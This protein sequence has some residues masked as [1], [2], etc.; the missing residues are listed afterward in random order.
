MAPPPLDPGDKDMLRLITCGSVDNGKSTL[1]GRLLFDAR[2]VPGDHLEALARD[3]K[4]YGT[5]G[6]SPDLALLVDGLQAE[7]EQ[8][9]TIDVAYRFFSTARRRF[10]VADTPGHAQYTRNMV[11]GASTADLAIVI[12]DARKGLLAQTFR[13]STI[14]ALMGVR[15]V[16]LAVNKMDLVDYSEQRFAEIVAT[17]SLL[18]R[19]LEL[20]AV[21]AIPT[22]ALRGDNVIEPGAAMPWYRGPTLL[23]HLETVDV[24]RG[25]TRPFRLAVQWINRNGADFRGYAGSVLG[26]SIRTGEEIVVQPSGASNRIARIVT[27]DGDLAEAGA[28]QAVTLTLTDAFDVARGDVLAA[29]DR[30][31]HVAD[32][33]ACHLVW[34]H[35]APMLPGRPYLLQLGTATLTA[36]VTE[37]KH[38]IDVEIGVHE[39]TKQ[40]ALNEIG[41]ANVALDRPAPFDVYNENRD[42]GSFIMIDRTSNATVGA[43][44]IRFPLRRASNLPWQA[45]A[46]DKASRAR[47]KH[48]RPCVLWF[49]GLSGSGK[50]TIADGVEKRLL[51][52]GRHTYSLDGDNVRHG[53][54]RDLGFTDADRVENV[55]RVIEVARLFCEAGLIVLVSVISPFRS[56]RQLARERMADDEFVEIFVDTPFAECERRDPKGLYR[57]AREGKITNFTG[58]DSP[59][60]APE[61][62]DIHI[63]TTEMSL[64]GEIES[65]MKVLRDRGVIG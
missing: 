17:Y 64:E 11:T 21:T 40:L 65:V 54:N 55:R 14:V 4:R 33:F 3:S 6:D 22:S 24:D 20:A 51:A 44:M 36:T 35:D 50:S 49:T 28:G 39:A 61:S 47:I 46:V 30:P 57:R 63:R 32:Q 43:G 2:L 38:R 29:T 18:A 9:I 37:L 31:P 16:V 34:M 42:T 5:V 1:I 41:F 48:Q 13:H 27:Q 59:Y 10:I 8:G 60:E 25:D 53:L 23:D 45:F 56:E 7:R 19:R 15:H 58:I 62:P 26:G 52:L 12:V